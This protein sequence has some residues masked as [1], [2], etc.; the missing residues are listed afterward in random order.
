MQP[1]Y[2]CSFDFATAANMISYSLIHRII[3]VMR[4]VYIP[5]YY[6]TAPC[7]DNQFKC[8]TSGICIQ[9]SLE[10]DGT[11]NCHDSSDEAMPKCLSTE[12]IIGIAVGGG[13]VLIAIIVVIV[14]CIV[15]YQR[16]K[17][18]RIIKVREILETFRLDAHLN[19]G[20]NI[21]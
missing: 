9:K 14:I 6:S 7:K 16:R 18:A 4:V 2:K 17:R 19:G 12:A 5:L 3:D 20:T 15:S 1:I 21:K 13:V 10:C 11:I 8:V